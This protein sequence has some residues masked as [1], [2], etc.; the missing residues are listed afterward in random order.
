M[1]EMDG[2]YGLAFFEKTTLFMHFTKF[3]IPR[4]KALAWCLAFFFTFFRRLWMRPV[5]DIVA[6]GMKCI[7]RIFGRIG[8]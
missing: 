4:S 5:C 6:D 1:S 8:R 2:I 3:E 7:I